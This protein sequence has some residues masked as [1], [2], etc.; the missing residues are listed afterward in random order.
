MRSTIL[1]LAV[2]ALLLGCNEKPKVQTPTADE[3]APIGTPA[4]RVQD[5]LIS[6][7]IQL[8]TMILQF[9]RALASADSS[10][11]TKLA[12]S[13]SFIEMRQH[14]KKIEFL[15]EYFFPTSAK[16]FNAAALPEVEE[17]DPN[18]VVIAPQGLQ[19]I[20]TYL[21]P[22]FDATKRQEVAD[23]VKALHPSVIRILQLTQS[24]ALEDASILTAVRYEIFR[25]I[26][27]GISGYDSPIAFNSIPE[28]NAAL[29]SLRETVEFYQQKQPR[30]N[31][32]AEKLDAAI[33]FTETYTGDFNSFDRLKF[34]TDYANPASVALHDACDAAG[35]KFVS[36][37]F[38]KIS[39]AA[40]TLFESSVLN[41]QD[42]APD[43]AKKQTDEKI[44]LGKTLF[45]DPILSENNQRACAS[46]HQPD[47]AFT[48]GLARALTITHDKTT[49]RNT[50]TVLNSAFQNSS[51]YDQRTFTLEDRVMFVVG[52]PN[53]MHSSLEAAAE[54]LNQSKDYTEQFQKAFGAGTPAL[55]GIG[56]ASINNAE[57]T[58]GAATA[59][60]IKV[61][62]ASYLRSL[63]SFNSRFDQYVR[64]DKTKM[65]D[66]EQHGFNLY[67]GKAK[68]GTCHFMPLFNGT[69]PP[70]FNKSEAEIIGVPRTVKW[71]AAVIDSDSGKFG[72]TGIRLQTFMFKTPTVRNAELTAPYMHNGVYQSLEQVMKFYNMGGGK[73]IGIDLPNQTL[74]PDTLGLTKQE[75]QAVIA[76]M[77]TLTD[78]SGLTARPTALPRFDDAKLNA[79]KIGGNY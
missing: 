62:I 20:E 36:S 49:L 8:D 23:L 50:P 56:G 14:Y 12:M 25:V 31:A 43:Y 38:N 16:E 79:R 1:T 70:N 55:A 40:K 5:S 57:P 66:D 2:L 29:R 67:M 51:S 78:T 15:T 11:Q 35:V 63:V 18:Q 24:R 46:C 75:I 54:K 65:T 6:R 72:V 68:C 34:I 21:Y 44:V 58:A 69:V 64:G 53:E 4:R 17:N 47:K 52:S 27:L 41:T 19:A 45:F 7:A 59:E 73:G 22:E 48:D 28:A 71:K 33:K 76:F 39:P 32:V 37:A 74:P 77:K 26:T 42:F 10:E 13:R 3:K 9:A 30:F 61:A 60:R